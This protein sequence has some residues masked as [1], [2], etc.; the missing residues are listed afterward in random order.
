MGPFS[1][2][3]KTAH[4][5]YDRPF[6]L[7]DKPFEAERKPAVREANAKWFQSTGEG[8]SRIFAPPA[9]TRYEFL[10]IEKPKSRES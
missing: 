8:F 2:T 9:T 6:I 7:Q 4:D 10:K 5:E 1:G 3:S